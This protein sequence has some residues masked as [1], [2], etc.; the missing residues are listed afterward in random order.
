MEIAKKPVILCILDGWGW[1]EEKTDNAVALARTPNW[2]R[3]LQTAPQSF[4][5]TC[6]LD[7]GLPQGQ[8]GNSE[9]GHMNLGAGRVVMQDLPRIDEAI[10]NK[11]LEKSLLQLLRGNGVWGNGVIEKK[12]TT[13]LPHYPTTL[14]LM[15]L[16]SPGGVHSHQDHLL[17]LAKILNDA[18]IK[19]LLHLWLDGRDTPPKSAGDYLK[20]LEQKLKSLSHVKVATVCGRYYAMDRDNRWERVKLAYD[21]MIDG[22]GAKAQSLD[23]AIGM[24]YAA[25]ETDEFV[26]PII[27]PDFRPMQEGDAI[28]C[29][30][31]R[32][33]RVR[34]ILTAFLDENFKEF[35]ARRVKFSSAIAMTEY[36]EDLAKNMQ[37]LFAPQSMQDILGEII[38]RE[39]LTQ[40]RLAETEKYPHVTF[41]FNGGKETPY[42][43]EDRI[44]VPSPKVATY[45]LQPEMSAFELTEK[46]TAAINSKKYDFILVNYANPDMVGHTGKLDAAIKAVEAV[47]QCLGRIMD[48]TEKAGGVML[49]TADHGNCEVMRDP[50]TG[51]PHTAHTLNPVKLFLFPGDTPLMN[52]RLADAA[53]TI[54]RLL[55]LPQPQAMTGQSLLAGENA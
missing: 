22:V 34:Q 38:A 2:D 18:G 42:P 40:L 43:G 27:L 3:L 33:D 26:K 36:S 35:A 37:I 14:H 32:S 21:A 19:T 25:G 39:N 6:G 47:D 7:V 52:G 15:G 55:G 9:V 30:N 8:M 29:A 12:A 49:V 13:P 46:L 48:A 16:Y 41:F 54:L 31:F 28:L 44:L 5:K 45:D 11:S 17:A 10:K 24:A 4:L 23:Q 50:E 20:D 51:A 53:P 1:R